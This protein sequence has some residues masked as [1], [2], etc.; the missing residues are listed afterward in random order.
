MSNDVKN[1][2][3][4]SNDIT[5]QNR[6]QT[7]FKS[8]LDLPDVDTCMA[9]LALVSQQKSASAIMR[10][11]G[12]PPSTHSNWKRRNSVNYDRVVEGLLR[13][14]V[15][16]DWFFAPSTD[17]FYPNVSSVVSETGTEYQSNE[18]VTLTLKALE[19]VEPIMQ[20]YKVEMTEQNRQIMAE[21]FLKRRGDGMLL[22][23]ALRQVAIAL[24]TAQ[25][26]AEG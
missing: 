5:A 11:L 17:L 19:H 23:T 22:D 20:H 7:T 1:N 18:A 13:H 10:W 15:S 2:R 12:L 26:N 9:R 25:G 21:T 3:I 6:P 16:L 24:A 4:V 8:N 14:N